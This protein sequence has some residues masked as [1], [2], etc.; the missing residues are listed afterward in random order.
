MSHKCPDCGQDWVK[1]N[2]A[3]GRYLFKAPDTEDAEERACPEC[4]D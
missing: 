4:Q 1:K 3:G 2:L